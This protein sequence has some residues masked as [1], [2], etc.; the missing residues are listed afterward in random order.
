MRREEKPLV[1]GRFSTGLWLAIV[2][3]SAGLLIANGTLEGY[4]VFGAVGGAACVVALSY[5]IRG[6]RDK[7]PALLATGEVLEPYSYSAQV[8][9]GIYL[10]LGLLAALVLP[11]GLS[12]VL[13]ASSWLGSVAGVIGGW[14]TSLLAYNALLSSW[15]RKHGG[16]LY[17]CHVWRGTKVIQKGL[18]FQK[19]AE[20]R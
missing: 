10:I 18:R 12:G 19:A 1:V 2:L 6:F 13:D 15:Q 5:R 9:M 8:H 7:A 20:P 11:L 3:A 14:L 17:Q 16:K 4:M